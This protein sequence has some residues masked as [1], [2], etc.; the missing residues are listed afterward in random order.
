MPPHLA[1]RDASALYLALNT[2]CQAIWTVLIEHIAPYAGGYFPAQA[3]R[4]AIDNMLKDELE[5]SGCL[6]SDQDYLRT[7]ATME[8]ELILLLVRLAKAELSL[9][10]FEHLIPTDD[11]TRRLAVTASRMVRA[12]ARSQLFRALQRVTSP[13]LAGI[14]YRRDI[15]YHDDDDEEDQPDKE[16][17]EQDEAMLAWGLYD[18]G[19]NT[20]DDEIC[21]ICQESLARE[22]D[23]EDV[24]REM[25][26]AE[27]VA[28][29]TIHTPCCGKAFHAYCLL[30]WIR[31]S[32]GDPLTKD[33]PLCREEFGEEFSI[34][35]YEMRIAS[36][37]TL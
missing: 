33:C 19:L 30:R 20:T 7:V 3:I 28:T 17:D 34:E 9:I 23:I 18:L 1:S 37:R 26:A 4:D 10:S 36:L 2:F 15:L 21:P 24:E 27:A 14:D 5:R 32:G 13:R 11:L 25:A 31:W 16:E 8:H 35:L 6:N 22:A 29:E 12:E